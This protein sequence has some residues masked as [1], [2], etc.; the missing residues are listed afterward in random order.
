MTDSSQFTLGHP[1]KVLTL[2]AV[3]L[4]QGCGDSDLSRNNALEVLRTSSPHEVL[5]LITYPVQ[6]SVK[7]PGTSD[8]Q[9]KSTEKK[10][11]LFLTG[12]DD[13]MGVF[14]RG[15]KG[16]EGEI[17]QKVAQ[18]QRMFAGG[19]AF[20]FS[21]SSRRSGS[22]LYL[23][24]ET[25]TNDKYCIASVSSPGRCYFVKSKCEVAEV[26]GISGEGIERLVD[27]V[28]T[29]ALTTSAVKFGFEGE[30][31]SINRTASFRLYDDGW[32]ILSKS[33]ETQGN[34]LS[35]ERAKL[36]AEQV[37]EKD[38]RVS[39]LEWRGIVLEDRRATLAAVVKTPWGTMSGG[40][41]YER[42]DDIG[43][44]LN[45]VS[46]TAGAGTSWWSPE[47]FVKVP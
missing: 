31:E 19:L 14:M 43:W 3:L 45:H 37:V 44:V 41:H 11:K 34:A 5:Q 20:S 23:D 6:L 24:V 39:L 4:L 33:A 17:I 36:A 10:V 9:M 27:Y 42:K 22:N 28:L 21:F 32:R 15:M 38:K 8:E 2:F 47:A 35:L 7:S 25:T 16:T 12:Q 46:F 29:C 13:S 40:F 26:S 30:A 1:V 18:L